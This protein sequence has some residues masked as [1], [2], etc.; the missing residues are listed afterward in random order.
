MK[1]SGYKTYIVAV[2][3]GIVFAAQQ[4]GYITPE[5]ATRL[6]ELL[7]VLGVATLRAAIGKIPV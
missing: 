7:G 4:L 2:L 6:Y 1:L 5:V 3:G